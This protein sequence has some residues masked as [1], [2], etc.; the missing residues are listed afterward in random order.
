MKRIVGAIALILVLLAIP[1]GIR[2]QSGAKLTLRAL[3]L[4]NFPLVGG[5]VEVRD[6]AG[7]SISNL[8]SENFIVLEDGGRREVQRVRLADSAWRVAVAINPA[9]P[10]AIR[11]SQG[12]TRYDYAAEALATWAVGLSADE[13]ARLGLSTPDGTEVAFS[14]PES[15][16]AALQTYE[17]DMG[18]LFPSLNALSAALQQ[19]AQPGEEANT[20]SAILLVTSMPSPTALQTLP[21]LQDQAL[22]LDVPVFVWLLD[23]NSRID[24]EGGAA[25]AALAESTGGAFFGFSEGEAFPDPAGYFGAMGSSYFFQYESA[26]RDTQEHGIAVQVESEAL[27]LSSAPLTVQLDLQAPNP[28]LV[29][30]PSIIER[31]P[32]AEDIKV[33]TPF[34]QPIEVIIEFPDDLE[35]N[36]VRT[37][38]LVNGVQVAENRAA[39]FTRFVWDLSA[40]DEPQQVFV[41]VEVEDELGLVGQSVEMPVQIA[42]VA[43][44]SG[45]QSVLARNIPLITLVAALVAAGA[46]FVLSGRKSPETL[47]RRQKK[48][49]D[50][51]APDPLFDSPLGAKATDPSAGSGHVADMARPRRTELGIEE[52]KPKLAAAPQLPPIYLVAV[53][54]GP[55][56]YSLPSVTKFDGY[57]LLIGSDREA[58]RLEVRDDSVEAQHTALRRREDGSFEVADLGTEAGTWLNYAP[59]TSEGATVHAGDLIHVGRVAFRFQ[60]QKPPTGTLSTGFA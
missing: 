39:P 43:S 54:T 2:A 42:V 18:E 6:A 30:P 44:A 47:L 3:Q 11:D 25:L 17:P 60:T 26:I 15:W 36:L 4:D 23:A 16:V 32:S 10:F 33:L 5:F 41:R 8:E 13:T 9:E 52:E 27:T 55:S 53:D 37:T 45:V 38:L 57:E 31:T 7:N 21:S 48:G 34:S 28:I 20:A 50:D 40:Y 12:F 59:V 24:S 58:C 56:G 51:S 14:S 35:R 29:S 22:A 1:Q 19:V 49:S 46:L